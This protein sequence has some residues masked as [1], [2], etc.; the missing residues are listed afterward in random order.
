MREGIVEKVDRTIFRGDATA[1]EDTA[2]I[3]GLETLTIGEET[4]KQSDKVKADKTLEAFL[5]FVDGIYATGL[6][7]L[8][9]VSSVGANTLWYSKIHTSA[10]DNQTIA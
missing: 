8:S 10:A 1:N 2:D 4:I 7:D 6:A 9:V 5:A 3:A